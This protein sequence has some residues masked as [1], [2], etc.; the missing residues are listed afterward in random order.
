VCWGFQPVFIFI[1]FHYDLFVDYD[2]SSGYNNV[3]YDNNHD[4]NEFNHD[5]HD[6]HDHNEEF[7]YDDDHKPR[8]NLHEQ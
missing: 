2:C 6:D 4:H 3:F 1:F 8:V 7:N 5:D